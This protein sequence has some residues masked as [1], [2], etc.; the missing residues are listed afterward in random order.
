[1]STAFQPWATSSAI[2]RCRRRSTPRLRRS[3]VDVRH[4][5]TVTAVRGGADARGDRA[6]RGEANERDPR[7]G[8]PP[9]PTAP[10]TRWRSPRD[11]ATTTGRSRSS[12][13]LR[14]ASP[15]GRNRVRALHARRS[16]R[17]SA[18]ARRLR[19][20][21][22]RDARS[23]AGIAGARR[24]GIP[25]ASSRATSARDRAASLASP[26]AARFLSSWNMPASLRAHACVALGNAAQT[27]HPVAGQGF[28]LGLR[29]A[30]ELARIVLDTP[31]ERT[32]RRR[33]ARADIRAAAAPIGWRVS[34]SR[35]DSCACSATIFRCCA[36][37][38]GWRSLCSTP[39]R[40]RKERSRARCCSAFAEIARRTR[41][42]G[43]K[44]RATRR[45][46]REEKS[47]GR[48]AHHV[49]RNGYNPLPPSQSPLRFFSFI[50]R[51]HRPLRHRQQSR[52]RADGGRHRSSVPPA[53]QAPRRGI[54]GV[55]DGRVESAVV[56]DGE[57][58]AAHRPSRRGRAHRRAD[59]RRRSRA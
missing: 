3:R 41:D 21:L 38:A 2:V 14:R 22:D 59:R 25:R 26:G 53:L 24:R 19:A 15:H 44:K 33:D 42:R 57:V 6:S 50:A 36:G 4:G 37:L 58:A 45:A 54:R 17:A 20:R 39:F 32:R 23:G 10:A 51:A 11:G 9:W 27:L 8:W 56:G 46:A 30:W 5:V 43:S 49:S 29:D 55:G 18:R 47:R 31:R 1:M 48:I 7:A 28:N 35:T 12:A 40:P 16:D 34:R 13:K 52:R